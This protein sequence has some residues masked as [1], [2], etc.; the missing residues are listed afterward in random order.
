MNIRICAK[1]IAV[2]LL[3]L[4]TSMCL[5][6]NC[7]WV[8]NSIIWSLA[9]FDYPPASAWYIVKV[10]NSSSGPLLVTVSLLNDRTLRE[11]SPLEDF[12]RAMMGRFHSVTRNL[13]PGQ[14]SIFELPSVLDPHLGILE[15][16][17]ITPVE[18]AGGVDRVQRMALSIV[19]WLDLGPGAAPSAFIITDE[20][21]VSLDVAFVSGIDFMS[22]I[23]SPV[24]GQEI[25]SATTGIVE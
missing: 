6:Q 8:S 19:P 7:V 1:K 14:K 3:V 10:E 13:D 18:N 16:C 5:Y 9:G 24:L 25:T 2:L 4:G 11:S 20:S 15:L 12:N 17:A 21:L 23:G 22:V